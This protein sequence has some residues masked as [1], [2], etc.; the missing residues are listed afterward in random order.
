VERVPFPAKLLS[1]EIK[2]TKIPQ[3]K[4]VY[5][6]KTY[7]KIFDDVKLRDESIV[8]CNTKEQVESEL[9][10]DEGKLLICDDFMAQASSTENKY[11]TEFFTDR[12]HHQNI[13]LIFLSQLLY[14]EK[15]RCWALNTQYYV[16]FKNH[17]QQQINTFFRNINP[18]LHKFLIDSYT[19][20]T[21]NRFGHFFMSLHGQTDDS[22]RYRSKVIPFEGMKIFLPKEHGAN[23]QQF[24]VP[25]ESS[26]K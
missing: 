7:E 15:G 20:C 6:Y 24:S 4:V 2:F 9:A 17:H 10:G 25:S 18:K 5:F 11:I 26:K 21:D 14:P 22:V 23:S 13:T 8:F 19:F 12:C 16:L 1:R 3:K